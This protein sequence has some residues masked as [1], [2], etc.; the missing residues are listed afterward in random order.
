MIFC[1]DG[2]S[3]VDADGKQSRCGSAQTANG[4]VPNLEQQNV[5]V[6]LAEAIRQSRSGRI[7]RRVNALIS[8][9][10]EDE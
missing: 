7:F 6:I 2:A 4:S 9:G 1:H 3:N 8:S 5:N 10:D